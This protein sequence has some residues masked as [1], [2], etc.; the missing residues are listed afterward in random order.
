MS[1]FINIWKYKVKPG[2]TKEFEDLYWN[3]GDW[4]KLFRKF[5]GY[6]KT[7]LIKDISDRDTYLTL[8]YWESRDSYYNFKQK[9]VN[10]FSL[11][12]KKG[13]ELTIEEKHLGEFTAV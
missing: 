3:E 13:E 8:D 5:S 9:S 7:E 12:D 6:I 2:K 11:I 1:T 10:E 4:V